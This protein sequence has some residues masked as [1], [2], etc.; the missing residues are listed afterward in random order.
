V[1]GEPAAV[2]AP[3]PA[4]PY[5]PH[6]WIVGAPEIGD[7]TWIG[8]FTVIDGSGGLTVGVGCDIS[9]GAQIYT[10]SSVRR[11]VSGRTFAEVER[12]PTRIGDRVF[13]GA[14]AVVNMGVTIGDEAVVAAGAVVTHDV[15]ART[16]VA[17]VPARA[18]A[19]VALDGGVR[20]LPMA[21][22]EKS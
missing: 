4:N 15:P 11:C 7:G 13:I 5:H 10:H 12:R 18:V 3:L 19:V 1:T 16:V 14:N 17:G 22:G 21:A 8:A 2:P 20:F 6:A 9:S